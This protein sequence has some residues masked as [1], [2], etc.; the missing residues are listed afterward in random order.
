[1][2]SGPQ[3]LSELHL[4]IKIFILDIFTCSVSHL[5]KNDLGFLLFLLW[6]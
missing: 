4:F 5:L 6:I 2:K 1:M 3:V